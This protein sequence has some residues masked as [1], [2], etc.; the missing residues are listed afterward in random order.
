[1]LERII[2]ASSEHGDVVLDPF[3]GCGT[4]V[5]AAQALNRR[6]IGIDVTHLAIN[7]IEYRLRTAFPEAKYFIHGL[8]KDLEGASKLAAENPY[9]FQYWACSLVKAHPAG[10]VADKGVDGF[11][12]FKPDGKTPEPAL[13]SVKGGKNITESMIRDLLGAM[14]LRKAKV[15]L[16]ITLTPPTRNMESRALE[17][18]Y[19]QSIF[20]THRRVQIL[21]IQEL[22]LEGRK[23]DIPYVDMSYTFKPSA[24]IRIDRQNKLL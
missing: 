3:C 21:T 11:I 15:G 10:K 9:E 20:G 2:Q 8:P 6:W 19:F 5:V 13:V 16:F 4:A 7:L 23:P 18:G 1:L 14:E 22:L 12:Y 17:A 24:R